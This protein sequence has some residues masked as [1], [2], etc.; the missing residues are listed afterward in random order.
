MVDL[1]RKNTVNGLLY[2]DD[3]NIFGWEIINEPRCSNNDSGVNDAPAECVT[4]IQSFIDDAAA[5]IKSIDRNHLVR[6]SPAGV[7][8]SASACAS[9]MPSTAGLTGHRNALTATVGDAAHPTTC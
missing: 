7:L 4:A 3:P 1:C 6:D 8:A 9:L 2:K 5:H